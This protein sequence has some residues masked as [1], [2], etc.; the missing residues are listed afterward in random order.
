MKKKLKWMKAEKHLDESRDW[1][2]ERETHH[3]LAGILLRSAMTYD[4]DEED[5]D[6]ELSAI[7][8]ALGLLHP[9]A[10][11]GAC[12]E[13]VT[14]GTTSVIH[15]F[16]DEF[17][18]DEGRIATCKATKVATM[19]VCELIKSTGFWNAKDIMNCLCETVD[20]LD[21]QRMQDELAGVETEGVTFCY[22]FE[23]GSMQV[24]EKDDNNEG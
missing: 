3:Q 6:K 24:I 11:F 23:E 2:G 10:V 13:L 18:E 12:S 4:K 1:L 20:L 8:M 9:V 14:E 7:G 5:D 16:F 19:A 22:N 17:D 21:K 15:K